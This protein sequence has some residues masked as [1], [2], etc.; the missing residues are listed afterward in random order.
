MSSD[1]DNK[2]TILVD[3]IQNQ[4]NN[5]NNDKK[6][7]YNDKRRVSKYLS[8]SIFGDECSLWNGYITTIKNDDRSSYINFYFNGKKYA[9]HRLLYQNY[10]GELLDSEYIKFNCE[11]KGKCCTIKHFDK[12]RK[13]DVVV[14]PIEKEKIINP[15][16]VDADPNDVDDL[17]NTNDVDANPD[18]NQD[19]NP[20]PNPDLNNPNNVDKIKAKTKAKTLK[21]IIVNFNL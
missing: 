5:V 10:V 8:T 16:D 12:V 3:L 4:K 14:K 21:N 11:N 15:D 7:L 13:N 17:N 9:L 20:N 19:A 18:A 6:L 1:K 2:D